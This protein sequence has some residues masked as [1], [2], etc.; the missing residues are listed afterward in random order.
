MDPREALAMLHRVCRT[1]P[2]VADDHD[3]VRMAVACIEEALN[4]TANSK[5]TKEEKAGKSKTTK[6]ETHGEPA[7]G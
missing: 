6:D 7:N 1:V 2:M 5:P 3:R 4:Q